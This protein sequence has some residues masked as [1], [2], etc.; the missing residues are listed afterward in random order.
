MRRIH[1][2][3]IDCHGD[4]VDFEVELVEGT[5]TENGCCRFINENPLD[6]IDK[7]SVDCYFCGELADE[8]DCIPADEYNGND[9][10]DICPACQ[11]KL[12]I[13]KKL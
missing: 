10:G 3:G 12:D 8:R 4:N 11:T 5:I 9:G 7:H 13:T 6:W 1:I 2:K